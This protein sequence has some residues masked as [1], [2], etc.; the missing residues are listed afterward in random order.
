M[1]DRE[2]AERL[3]VGISACF[4]HSDARAAD[5][6][7]QDAA[8]RRAVDGALGDVGGALAVM[9]PSPAGDTQT[10]DVALDHYAERSTALVLA[11]RRRR[12]PGSYGEEPLHAEW[13]GRPRP[14]PLRD[15]AAARV[16]RARQAG[17]R[18]LP[19]PA[20][21]ERRPRR[22]AVPGHRHA[23]PSALR[24][25][26]RRDLRPQLPCGRR[27]SRARAWR[28]S[29]E[30]AGRDVNSVH[31]QAVKDLAP[32]L[33]VEAPAPTTAWSR[34]SASPG[35]ASWRRC[36]GTPNSIAARRRHARRH[37]PMLDDFLAAAASAPD[38]PHEPPHEDRQ[39][40]H[41]RADRRAARRRRGQRRRQ[42]RQARAPP[43]R[44]GG[45]TP[46]ARAHRRPSTRF[47]AAL[48]L[49]RS[50][51]SRATLTAEV[52]KP[53]AQ[54]RNELNGFLGRHRLLPRR[55]RARSIATEK[56]FDDAS[57]CTERIAHEPLGVI[58]N[59]SA[60]NYPYF[61]GGNVFVPALLTGN[62]VLYK[63]SEFATL[64][65][66][67]IAGCCTR[68]ACP[69]TSSPVVGGG[70]GG[71]G[72]AR[73]ARRRRV[74]HRLG[75]RPAR[76]IAAAVAPRMIAAAA[77]AGRQGP[78]LRLRRRRRRRRRPR[79]WPTARSTTPARA[80]ARSSGST[81]TRRS[82]TRSSMRSS[83][84]RRASRSATR[85]T[86]APTSAR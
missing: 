27:S 73:A 68:R 85:P 31:H 60:W 40:R 80:A 25:P 82:T 44:L 30:G 14:R 3:K 4:F 9:I 49:R 76:S 75:T 17:A 16:R 86:T 77:R 1:K 7:G 79:R 66:M 24:A 70:R 12:L 61:V 59:I 6:Q 2:N 43:S 32:G 36:S 35:G 56:V 37:G 39:S 20:A 10:G 53:I 57:A 64:T 22:D 55:G 84:G 50:R 46:L 47:R 83:R 5:L 15:R 34:R 48:V 19:R 38:T 42:D 51:R 45:A 65:G 58:A 52:G 69:T 8:V 11:R 81:S 41:R 26:R 29:I 33:V 74:L 54:S 72:A 62:A 63:P 21:D 78:D 67:Q 18:H 23:D 13:D 28:R 71:R